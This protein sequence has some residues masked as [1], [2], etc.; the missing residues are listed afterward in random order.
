M[1]RT[2]VMTVAIGVF[3]APA[4]AQQQSMQTIRQVLSFLVTNQSVATDDFVKD[5]E[6]AEAT[7][8][9]IA[10]ALLLQLGRLP[11]TSSS[12]GFTYRL[13]RELGTM[14]RSSLSFGPFF[15]ER[16]LTAGRGRASFGV[17]YQ[18][19][20]FGTL[21][22]YSLEDGTFLIS[23]NQ[24]RDELTPFDVETL[25]LRLRTTTVI[26]SLSVGVTDRFDVSVAVPVVR[27]ELEGERV[28]TYRGRRLVQAHAVATHTGVAD[29]AVRS[30]FLVAGK[31]GN[32]FGIGADIRL[33]TGDDENLL[34]AGRR[35]TRFFAIA[36]AESGP[37]SLHANLSYT[38]GGVSNEL[39]YGAAV[40]AAASPRVTLAGELLMRRVSD[41]QEITRVSLPHPSYRNHPIG[42]NTIRLMPGGPSRTTAAGVVGMKWN[43]SETWLLNASVLFPLTDAG[44]N[45]KIVPTVTVDYVW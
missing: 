17:S 25:T 36:S 2:L 5:R 24:F 9:T 14:T 33:P 13:D 19:A 7:S 21:D 28:N 15:T 22:G 4:A 35:A 42:V 6:A 11:L 37:G 34:G 31:D 8:Q 39:A 12:G 30:K 1:M 45:A 10:R 41:L 23:A 29:I 43:M 3:A 18:V 32:G 20:R 16:A 40:A 38:A 26:P 44:L 27:L